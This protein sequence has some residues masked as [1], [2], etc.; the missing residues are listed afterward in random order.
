ML[1]CILHMFINHA[2]HI[3]ISTAKP[4]LGSV[5]DDVVYKISEDT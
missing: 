1:F 5:S 4:Q 2:K 3:W